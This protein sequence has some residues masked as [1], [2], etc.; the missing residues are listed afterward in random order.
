MIV[1]LMLDAKRKSGWCFNGFCNDS[2]LMIIDNADSNADSKEAAEA[3][4]FSIFYWG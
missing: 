3:L 2:W 1:E 4:E